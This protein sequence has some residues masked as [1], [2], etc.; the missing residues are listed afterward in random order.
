MLILCL[1]GVFLNI[2][3]SRLCFFAGLP[4]FLDTIL[5]I[6]VTLICGL[7]LGILC[8]ALTNIIYH[9]IFGYGWEAYLFT[10]CN[11]ATAIVTWC[12][13]RFFKQ[14]LTGQEPPTSPNGRSFQV[15]PTGSKER[16]FRRINLPSNQ[17]GSV[18]DKVIILI[19]FSFALC[20]AMSILGGLIATLIIVINSSYSDAK[21]ISG[22]LSATMFGQNVPLPLKE[23]IS[24]IPINIIDRLISVFAGYGIALLVRRLNTSAHL[25][26]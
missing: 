13:Y 6:T 17:L 20:L 24:R 26:A 7:P 4:L 10:L 23:I 18:M 11:I 22:V 19:L 8:G 14:E 3:I 21:G 15:V 16:S 2:A 1:A 9:S 25:Q 12:F 5:T